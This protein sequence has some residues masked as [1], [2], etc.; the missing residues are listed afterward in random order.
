MSTEK[1][2]VDSRIP[3]TLKCPVAFGSTMVTQILFNKPKAKHMRKMTFPLNSGDLLDLAI[4]VGDQPKL[5]IDEL[6]AVDTLAVIDVMAN[7]LQGG[8]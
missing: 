5:V 1:D 3:Y 2:K 8:Q 4:A 6:E 7:F